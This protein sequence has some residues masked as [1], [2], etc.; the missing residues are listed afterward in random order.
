VKLH[1]V[2]AP[3]ATDAGEQFALAAAGAWATGDA[4]VG[5]AVD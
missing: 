2:S 4:G 3:A 1:V 5:A